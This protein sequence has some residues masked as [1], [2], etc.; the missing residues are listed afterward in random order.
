MGNETYVFFAMNPN[1]APTSSIS[2][3][4]YTYHLP[5]NRIAAH[6]AEP[7]DA[8]KLL[9]YDQ[10]NMTHTHFRCLS[11][12]VPAH[13]LLVFNDTKVIPARI[14]FRRDTG[15]I[16]E[17]FLLQP[18]NN[19][20][21]VHEAMRQTAGCTWQC[22]IGNKKRWKPGETLQAAAGEATVSAILVDAE[23]NL[24][25]F[26]WQPAHL[27]FSE[28]LPHL[29][30]IPLPPYLNRQATGKDTEQYQTVYSRHEG[31]VA[32]PTAGLHFTDGVLESLK[33]K[34]VDCEFITLHVGAGTFQPIKAE[35]VLH[36]P[37][38]TE[39]MVFTKNS[40]AKL[41][42]TPDS[43]FAVG[44]T[45][46]RSLESLYWYGVK[47][48]EGETRFFIEKLY[49]YQNHAPLPTAGAAFRAVLESME[50]QNLDELAGETQIMIVPGYVFR[51]CKGLV[52]NY[53]QPGSTLILLVA[54]FLGPDWRRVYEAALENEYRFLSYGD[55]SLLVPRQV[56]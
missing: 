11:D 51:V 43:I 44:T 8:S 41:A 36:H 2:L 32:A 4:D 23:T 6:P 20:Q 56:L 19:D 17:V 37:M 16:V 40:I 22:M 13:T 1:D 30:N 48:L 42:Q 5:E 26:S 55:S 21:P 12:F 39:Q 7:R 29:G 35:N 49:P 45:S 31:A 34:G 47:L 27:P 9:V 46:M 15:G 14:F 25:H 24:V 33:S 10:G 50:S 28:V 53:H 38:H 52:T 54:A 3:Q 18:Q